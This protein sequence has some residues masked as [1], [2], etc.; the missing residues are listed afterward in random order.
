MQEED[1]DRLLPIL[2]RPY[3]STTFDRAFPYYKDGLNV[4]ARRVLYV[5]F[6]E[7]YFTVT[8]KSAKIVGAVIGDYHP[9]GDKSVYDVL[10]GMGANF[11]KNYPFVTPQGNFGNMNGDPAA[12]MR[13]TEARLSEFG[14]DVFENP[15][16][17]KQAIDWQDNYSDDTKEPIYLSTKLPIVLLNGAAGIGN[18]YRCSI[19]GHTL[20]DVVTMIK[21]YKNNKNICLSDL[22][23]GIYP[24]FPTGGIVTNKDDIEAVY[25]GLKPTGTIRMKAD[26]EIDRENNTIKI[27][28]MPYNMKWHSVV[29]KIKELI[30]DKKNIILSDIKTPVE[31]KIVIDGENYMQYG[32]ICSKDSNLVEIANELINKVLSSSYDIDLMMNYGRS[33]DSVTFK[34]II[35]QW[36]ESRS[37]SLNRKYEHVLT[38]LRTDKHINEGILKIYD[39]MDDIIELFKKY[40]DLKEISEILMKRYGLTEIQSKYIAERQLRQLSQRSKE[41]LIADIARIESKME[42]YKYYR[43]HIEDIIVQ[44]ADELLVKYK[45]PRRTIILDNNSTDNSSIEIMSGGILVSRN[46]LALFTINDITNSKTVLNGLKSVKINGKNVKE[47]IAAHEIE[48]KLEGLIIVTRNGQARYVSV[49]EIGVINNWKSIDTLD[50]FIDVVPVYDYD[51]DKFMV[52]SSDNKLKIVNVNEFKNKFVSLSSSDVKAVSRVDDHIMDMIL[53]RGDGKYLT[54]TSDSINILSRTAAGVL[55]GFDHTND[56]FFLKQINH[57][58][59]NNLVVSIVN[60]NLDGFIM[61]QDLC[62]IDIGKRTNKPSS[63][64]SIGGKRVIGLNFINTSLKQTKCCLIGRTTTVQLKIINFKIQNGVHKP[65]GHN[66]L[67]IIQMKT[68]D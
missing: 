28:S 56:D 2:M 40:N 41:N 63:L 8:K 5:M 24:E 54:F 1:I 6:K 47:I 53:M 7:G 29:A 14:Q 39:H 38:K 60:D 23:D 45:R 17:F 37:V 4:S 19:P 62:F 20:E 44:E 27:L 57:D 18:I 10:V 35:A 15:E 46:Q 51:K 43:S 32:L 50:Y 65:L 48:D 9:H 26:I 34:D 3:A 61:L 13:Y 33:V 36:F 52:F 59:F 49:S 55:T 11:V 21:R 66:V 30:T 64:K 67:G 58:D 31:N 25:K 16:K 42:E 12:S 22:M 68:L